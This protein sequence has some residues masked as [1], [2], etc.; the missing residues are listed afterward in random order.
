MFGGVYNSRRVL[1][2]GHTGFKGSWLCKWLEFL[3]AETA[4]YSLAPITN[5]NHFELSNLKVKSYIHDIRDYDLLRKVMGDFKPEFVFHL[6]AQPSVLESYNNPLDTYSTN[7]MGCANVLE[8]TRHTDTV[9]SVVVVTTDKVYRNNEWNYGYRE[10]DELGGHDP[11]S[12]SKA[13]TELVTESYIKSFSTTNTD[14]PLIASARAGNVVG[15]GDWTENRIIKDAVVA[16]SK[17]KKLLIRNPNSSRPWQHVLEPLSGYLLLGQHLYQRNFDIVGS[18]NFGPALNSN[19][20]VK[21]LVRL[22]SEEWDKVVGDC[23]INSQA[24]HE[25]Q[26]LMIDSTKARSTLGWN[27]VWDI[28]KTVQYTMEWYRTYFEENFVITDKQI[29]NYLT[30]AKENKSIWAYQ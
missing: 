28:K 3:G 27:P 29:K 8:A 13:S 30:E 25:A 23:H 5:P 20:T 9:K 21:E 24:R 17:D 4:G 18:W 15:G 11:Y 6:A 10:N 16:A 7:V 26:S 22:M 19:L 14:M 1:V 2:T 12:A